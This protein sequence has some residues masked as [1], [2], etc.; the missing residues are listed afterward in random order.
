MSG[1]ANAS[2]IW[3]WLGVGVLLVIALAAL[4]L[5]LRTAP[6]PVETTETNTD[7]TA[8]P[9]RGFSLSPKSFG[10]TDYAAFFEEV[11]QNGNVLSWAGQYSDLKK[12][13]GN[14]AKLVLSEAKKR[15][16]TP[17]L[18]VGPADREVFDGIFQ[19][20]FRTAILEF[21]QE[22]SVPYIGLGNE[23]DAMY[24]QSPARYASFVGTIES[25]AA[26]IHQASLT[27]K[28]FT[29]FQLERTKGLHGGLFGGTNDP[30]KNYWT[31]VADIQGLDFI[32]FTSYPCLIY[33]EPSEIPE[34][35]YSDIQ[36]RTDL[37]VAFTEIGWFR[38]T[39]VAG[40]DSD[41]AE[42]SA[43]ISRFDELTKRLEPTF[44]IWPFL[45]DQAVQAPF[46]SMGLLG[47]TQESSL[48]LSAWDA[49]RKRN[50]TVTE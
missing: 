34:E 50:T 45:Y 8:Q 21:I 33:K 22:N 46:A 28:V 29:V 16:L 5:G 42:Q 1:M 44:V 12:T 15:N 9:L 23:I 43:F 30:N 6:K 17:V 7:K 4:I 3:K 25:L 10:A 11:E 35:Y 49:Y 47:T 37:P 48:G 36:N 39:P 19:Q 2:R 24:E 41:E 27:T 26:E 32:A 13:T 20:G 40:W 18:L 31:Q 14:T 38:T